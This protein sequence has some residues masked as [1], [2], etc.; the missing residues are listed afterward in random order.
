MVA[1][2]DGFQAMKKRFSCQEN[3]IFTPRQKC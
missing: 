1:V 2:D 3:R